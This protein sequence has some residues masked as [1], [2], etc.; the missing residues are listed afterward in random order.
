MQNFKDLTIKVRQNVKNRKRCRGK[1]KIGSYGIHVNKNDMI[2]KL[3][4]R[5]VTLCHVIMSVLVAAKRERKIA[6]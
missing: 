1:N 6:S 2:T 5:F 3:N 4:N